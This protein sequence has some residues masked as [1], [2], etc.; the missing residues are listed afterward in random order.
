MII[1]D[2]LD[3]ELPDIVQSLVI[4]DPYSD[5]QMI[6]DTAT[7]KNAYKQ[8]VLKQKL[9]IKDLFRKTRIDFVDL[10]TQH[11]FVSPVIDFLKNRTTGGRE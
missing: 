3:E 8:E 5:S 7:A 1:R 4:Q 6:V 10:N 2:Q 11:S 9:M